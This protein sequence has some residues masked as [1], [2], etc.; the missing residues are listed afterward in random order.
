MS[1]IKTWLNDF[2][3]KRWLPLIVV[4]KLVVFLYF[5][6]QLKATSPDV[7]VG[8]WAA[9]TG[10]TPG[11]Y[12][13]A[14][15]LAEG[16]GYD[17]ACRMPG[18]IPMYVPMAMLFGE[19]GA[20][21]SMI[22]LQFL[23]SAISI[24]LLGKWAYFIFKKKWVFIITVLLFAISSFTSIWDHYLM[25][26]SYS[27]SF[28]IFSIYFLQRYQISQ[29]NKSLLW[30]GLFLAWAVFFRQ[31]FIVAFPIIFIILIIWNWKKWSLMLASLIVFIFP[32]VLSLGL[33]IG[34]NRQQ[35]NREVVFTT[36]IEECFST[37]SVEYQ[38]MTKFLIDMGYGEPFWTD[39]SVVQWMIRS[40]E[41]QKMPNIPDRHF[42]T[43]CNADS[44]MLLRENFRVYLKSESP[45]KDS[46]AVTLR[47][48][49]TRYSNAY[50]TEK[51]FNYYVLNR[52][53]H[54]QQLLVPL[55]IDNLPGPAFHEMNF[56]EK[57][58]KIFYLVLF[59]VV[60]IVGMLV[61]VGLFFTKNNSERWW[62]MLPLG[63]VFAL[64][65]ILG[66]VEQRYLV[67]VYPFMIVAVAFAI[68]RFIKEPQSN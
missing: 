18:L 25:S 42:T 33:W 21:I 13:P 16:K 23:L 31:I 22:F 29:K 59:T 15:H 37:Y 49:I 45:V 1:I 5:A 35:F 3:W 48:R 10:D 47:E 61:M 24:Y 68:S 2:S 27:T 34:Y 44:L 57:I 4:I 14:Q 39:G 53:R 19:E 12:D 26:D 38:M 20:K 51:K 32:L 65:M 64:T 60:V 55:R 67:P 8:G 54:A 43:Q 63:L 58:I 66:F 7:L 50:H 36:P 56:V 17:S 11:Y 62:W 30:A 46:A 41:N 40:K 52:L 9:T 28:F 6:F